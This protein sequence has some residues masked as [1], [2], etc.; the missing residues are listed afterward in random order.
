[1]KTAKKIFSLILTAVMAFSVFSAS[2]NALFVSNS[3]PMTIDEQSK[4]ICDIIKENS[5][6]DIEQFVTSIPDL[7]APARFMNKI[8]IIDLDVFCDLMF[9]LRD[10]C[11]EKDEIL[12]GKIF[13]FIGA[14]FKGFESAEVKLEE[15]EDGIYEFIIYLKC[16]DGDS[17][18]LTSGG[19]YNPETGLFY[20]KDEKGMFDIGFN[21]DLNEMIVYATVNS[22]MR[23]FGF[24]LEYDLF[25]Y[26]TPFFFY[27]TR[28][29]KFYYAGKEWMIQ[30]WKGLY[31]A[32]NGAEVGV[33]NRTPLMP[34]GSYYNCADDDDMLNMS[35]DLYHGDELLFSRPESRHWWVNGFQLSKELYSAKELTLRF[36][37]EMKDEAMLKAF[38]RSVD[39]EIHRDVSYTVDGLKV[40]LTW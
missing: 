35:F 31:I 9:R 27:N 14:Y 12:P 22:W 39:R 10:E 23:D 2:G 13:Y 11:Y 25:C 3:L 28:R 33:Y 29:F 20:G 8:A 7:S 40:C 21:F 5:Y 36:T 4:E 1:M 15:Q 34:P 18:V 38:L 6:V 37:I 32:A 16:A 17:I 26:T 24:C 30:A 19:Y